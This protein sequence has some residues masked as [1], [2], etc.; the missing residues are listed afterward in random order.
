MTSIPP[1]YAPDESKGLYP[2]V[3]G[4]PPQQ[5][6]QQPGVYTNPGTASV[7]YYPSGP[8]QQQPQQLVITH[9][10][11]VIVATQQ[12]PHPSFVCHIIF[13]CC[14]FLCCFWP[15]GLIAFVLAGK[16]TRVQILID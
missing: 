7:T 2:T 3:Q 11:P 13:S 4:Y 5:Q 8:P 6:Q 9:P 16:K 15:L 1:P 12:Q 14:T 10:A